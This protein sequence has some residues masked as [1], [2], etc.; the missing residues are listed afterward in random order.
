MAIGDTKRLTLTTDA[1]HSFSVNVTLNASVYSGFIFQ[2][3]SQYHNIKLSNST[4]FP[5]DWT[6][7][8][9]SVGLWNQYRTSLTSLTFYVKISCN[10]CNGTKSVPILSAV[11]TID[12]EGRFIYNVII[13]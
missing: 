11:T 13:N 12:N 9:T 2:L 7:S 10:T 3:H 4:K 1:L 8:G 6:V 5:Y